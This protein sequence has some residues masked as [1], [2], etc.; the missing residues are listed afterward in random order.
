MYAVRLELLFVLEPELEELYDLPQNQ[1]PA[2]LNQHYQ[3]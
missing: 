1:R 2:A 3:R